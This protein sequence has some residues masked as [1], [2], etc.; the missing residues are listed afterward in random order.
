M[1]LSQ[2]TALTASSLTIKGH[3]L[4]LTGGATMSVAGDLFRIADGSTL[5]LTNGALLSLSGGSTLNIT[6]ALI[7]FIGTGN[8]LSITNGLCGRGGCTMIANLPVLLTGGGTAER[9][10][11]PRS[12][13]WPATP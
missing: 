3:A 9:L 5:T 12:R 8:T 6:G 10:Q 4:S 2:L 7:N 1:K 13:T 11:Q